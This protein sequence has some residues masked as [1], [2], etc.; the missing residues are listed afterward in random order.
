MVSLVV[1]VLEE[2]RDGPSKVAFSQG[3][4]ST[5]TLV[6]DPAHKSFGVHIGVSRQL[7]R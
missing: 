4:H 1:V 7:H 5:E 6:L 2:L 3:N